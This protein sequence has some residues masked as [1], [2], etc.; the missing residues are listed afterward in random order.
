[1][2]QCPFCGQSFYSAEELQMHILTAHQEEAMN[3]VKEMMETFSKVEQESR[4]PTV[5]LDLTRLWV[6]MAPKKEITKEEILET[7]KFFLE[8]IRPK[9]TPMGDLL[10]Q[11]LRRQRGDK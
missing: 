4:F 9:T 8:G 6:E 1:M 7:Y 2:N 5:A 10:E 11:W 3:Q